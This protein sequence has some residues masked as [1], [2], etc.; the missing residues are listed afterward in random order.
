MT[1]LQG[2]QHVFMGL[3]GRPKCGH[4]AQGGRRTPRHIIAVLAELDGVDVLGG[5]VQLEVLDHQRGASVPRLGGPR[6]PHVQLILQSHDLVGGVPGWV[7]RMGGDG[8]G[9]GMPVRDS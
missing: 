2:V 8:R 1:D 6:G 5:E 3:R 9:Q 7:E 4:K